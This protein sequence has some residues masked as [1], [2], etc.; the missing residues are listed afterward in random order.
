MTSKQVVAALTGI[1]LLPI[2]NT[3]AKAE[4]RADFTASTQKGTAPITV[5]FADKSTGK[6][7]SWKWDLGNGYFSFRQ[8]PIASYSQPGTYQVKL[9]VKNIYGADSVVKKHF[10]VVE[11][12]PTV[13]F[14]ASATE[15]CFPLPV[16]FTDNSTVA[17]GTIVKREWNF[18]DGTTST[19]ANPQH[20]YNT[21]GS[22]SVTLKITNS[23]GAVQKQVKP[24]FIQIDD[25]VRADFEVSAKP[26][27]LPVRFVNESTASSEMA[28]Q[29][30]FGDGEITDKAEP[31]HT[32]VKSGQYAV[33][34]TATTASGCSATLV[35]ELAVQL[36]PTANGGYTRQVRWIEKSPA[37]LTQQRLAVKKTARK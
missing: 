26:G 6:P 31:D 22:F 15:G 33:R 23:N 2:F 21:A 29:W 9:V 17:N 25:G 20:I 1:L 24:A 35:K 27:C 11:E 34:L 3:S 28:F 32:F 12:K 13:A 16:S 10:I 37:L 8:H 30:S 36:I 5:R 19:E 4:I 14:V 7:S 18:G